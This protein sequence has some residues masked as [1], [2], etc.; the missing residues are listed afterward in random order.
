MNY[1]NNAGKCKDRRLDYGN[2][3]S[4]DG[5][6]LTELM[7][8]V[9]V[10]GILAGLSLPRFAAGIAASQSRV[11]QANLRV[12]NQVSDVY[13]VTHGQTI[14]TVSVVDAETAL[15]LQRNTLVG[16]YLQ[17]AI[18]AQRPGEHF[19]WLFDSEEGRG[20]WLYSVH[21][22]AAQPFAGLGFAGMESQEFA[23]LQARYGQSGASWSLVE[24]IGLQTT[25]NGTDLV[26]FENRQSEYTLTTRF[27]MQS[28]TS[29]RGG[30]G[31]AFETTIAGD[32]PTNNADTGYILQ[33][34]RGF[35]EVVLRKRIHSTES[36]AEDR[37]LARI[38]NRSTSTIKNE[39]I[40]YRNSDW[41]EQE[42]ELTIAVQD[43]STPGTRLLTVYLDGVA[44]LENF[45]IDSQVDPANNFVGLRGWVGEGVIISDMIVD[46]L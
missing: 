46:A 7:V 10:L 14:E 44:I 45:V 18:T 31:I 17:D 40:P 34:D 1:W 19:Y 6:T 41:W 4:N 42:R 12:L 13:R 20:R 37:L 25:G 29:N 36:N 21:Q 11:D 5:F 27:Q 15:A 8:V 16:N 43:S 35:S 2:W 24:G 22:L 38:G 9:V 32:G 3:R 33:F 26:F 39:A 23:D 30:L 28:S